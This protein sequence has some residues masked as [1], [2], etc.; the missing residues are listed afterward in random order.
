MDG[1]LYKDRDHIL[2]CIVYNVRRINWVFVGA[3]AVQ[4]A[5]EQHSVG[6]EWTRDTGH[7][8]ALA[9]IGGS[10]RPHKYMSS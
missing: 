2:Y 5:A 7:G 3:D 6:C 8:T 10:V 9:G 1:K 4:F